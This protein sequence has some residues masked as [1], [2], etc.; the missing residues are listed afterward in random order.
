MN[1]YISRG[2]SGFRVLKFNNAR[3]PTDISIR[4]AVS[5]RFQSYPTCQEACITECEG[6][7]DCLERVEAQLD[8][9][10]LAHIDAADCESLP[11]CYNDVSVYHANFCAG[12]DEQDPRVL[13]AAFKKAEVRPRTPPGACPAWC[14][15]ISRHTA[16]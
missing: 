3:E 8:K 15:R 16:A 2:G 7:A 10:S 9:G 1:D 6:D 12:R 13:C 14:T 5:D 4:E 11:N